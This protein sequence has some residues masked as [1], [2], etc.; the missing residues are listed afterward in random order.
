[1]KLKM[2]RSTKI[3]MS[4]I[5]VIGVIAFI[6]GTLSQFKAK[7][8]ITNPFALGTID[9]EIE[10]TFDPPEKWD[11][12]TTEKKVQIQNVGSAEALIRVA[13]VPRWENADGTPFAGDTQLIK[14]SVP[15]S[16]T[17]GWVD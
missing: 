11:G 1:M 7:D 6:P 17:P 16:T 5:F 12:T 4:I 10:E 14:L 2:K 13:L 8:E 9:I 3:L 15:A